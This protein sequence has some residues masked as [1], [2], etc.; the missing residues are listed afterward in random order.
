MKLEAIHVSHGFYRKS[1]FFSVLQDIHLA[2][3]S[4][5]FLVIRGRS[6]SGKTTLLSILLGLL[7]PQKGTVVIDGHSVL[8]LSDREAC[9]LRNHRIGYASQQ[10]VLLESLSVL[11]NVRIAAHLQKGT[12]E[13]PGRAHELLSLLGIEALAES[14]PSTLSGGELRRAALARALMNDPDMVIAD[15][16]LASL[17]EESARNVVALLSD[18][19]RQG[20][21]VLMVSHGEEGL[22][23]ASRVLE[24]RNGQ[25]SDYNNKEQQK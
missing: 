17:D 6:G 14:F 8:S 3:Q 15:E 13:I 4:G 24:L 5:D 9:D 25:L 1:R 10:S 18:L 12:K 16:P 11:D 7:H 21:A 22:R 19:A 2:I 20:K 23:S